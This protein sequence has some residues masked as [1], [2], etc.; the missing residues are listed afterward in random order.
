M[1]LV[2]PHMHMSLFS[3]FIRDFPEDGHVETET[4]DCKCRIISPLYI[5]WRTLKIAVMFG[6]FSSI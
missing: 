5:I 4:C 1:V 6:S 3:S 2:T